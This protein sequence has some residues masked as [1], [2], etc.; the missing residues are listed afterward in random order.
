[1]T[2]GGMTSLI[3][4]KNS[5]SSMFIQLENVIFEIESFV[6]KITYLLEIQKPFNFQ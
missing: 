1:M 3:F 4:L 2:F 6:W 5:Y